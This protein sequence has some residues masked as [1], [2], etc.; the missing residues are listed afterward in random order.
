MP[1]KE[2]A[3]E[4]IRCRYFRWRLRKVEGVWKADGRSNRPKIGRLSLRTRNFEIALKRLTDLDVFWAVKKGL[5]P[6]DLLA[7]SERN[8]I[9]IREGCAKFLEHCGRDPM[10]GGLKP[11]SF[12]KY[13][14]ELEKFRTFSQ[15]KNVT[16]WSEVSDSL[17]DKYWTYLEQTLNNRP[18]TIC[19]AIGILKQTNKWLIEEDLLDSAFLLKRKVKKAQGT[20]HYCWQPNEVQ[21]ILELARQDR[22]LAWLWPVL[23]T[24][25][26][27]G[28]RIGEAR[29]LRWSDVDLNNKLLHIVDE[30]GQ[31]HGQSAIRQTK[32]GKS[33]TIPLRDELV[34][35]LR[36]ME[37]QG[38]NVF[39][40][41]TGEPLSDTTT[42]E[43]LKRDLLKPLAHRFPS[44]EGRKGFADGV[45]H[46]FRHYFCSMCAASGNVSEFTLREWMGHSDSEMVRHYFHLHNSQ[47]HQ[48]MAQVNF[49]NSIPAMGNQPNPELN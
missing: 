4:T 16:D 49:S 48:Q 2:S 39:H 43:A 25:A 41:S 46:S 5:A 7:K 31:K 19:T 45:L 47:A 6:R 42:R 14:G 26:Y 27:T 15:G 34:T 10:L 29:Q 13:K 1:K 35:V 32:S 40:S 8:S 17:L 37:R 24:L 36:S 12:K 20:K 23:M 18:K 44:E 22:T 38:P 11:R 30:S 21:A 3:G 33:R 28:I 9:G